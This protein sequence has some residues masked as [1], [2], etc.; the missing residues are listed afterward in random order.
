MATVAPTDGVA[1]DLAAALENWPAVLA[2]LAEADGPA[3]CLRELRPTAVDGDE[4]VLGGS[5]YA[6]EMGEDP[7]RLGR[8]ARAAARSF[9]RPLRLRAGETVVAAGADSASPPESPPPPPPSARSEMRASAAPSTP[10]W[11]EVEP[12]PAPVASDD[13]DAPDFDALPPPDDSDDPP[14]STDD[15][16]SD[17]PDED[18]AAADEAHQAAIAA[19]YTDPAVR[20]VM[21]AFKA[22]MVRIE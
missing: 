21:D 8:L 5:P 22:R 20:R 3:G 9:G 11:N 10:P 4:I 13:A 7:R 18:A 1:L 12:P 19:A 2:A 17:A 6:L 14:A 15:P 16:A